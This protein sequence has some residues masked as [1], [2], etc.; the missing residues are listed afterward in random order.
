MKTK[1]VSCFYI[2]LLKKIDEFQFEAHVRVDQELL[3]T[4]E[5]KN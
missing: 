3:W 5:N 4:N 2:Y 1:S